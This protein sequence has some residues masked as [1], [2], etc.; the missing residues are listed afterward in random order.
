M[1]SSDRTILVVLPILALAIGFWMLVVSPK[2]SEVS[3]LDGEITTLQASIDSA[4]TEVAIA[5]QAQAAFPKNYARLVSLGT[6]V[7]EDDDQATLVHDLSEL[8]RQD[9]LSFRSFV[10]SPASDVAAPAAPAATAPTDP[11]S[12]APAEGTTTTT[13]AAPATEASAAGLPLGATVGPAGLPVTPYNLKYFG[14]FF[15]TADLFAALDA[16]V[17]VD[18]EG[19]PDVSGRLVTIDGFAMSADPI[20]GFPRVQTELAITTY[21]VPAEQGLSAG[22]T[23]AGPAPLAPPPTTVAET[24]DPTAA[25]TTAAVAP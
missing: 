21:L 20:R 22:A 24:A 18:D 17:D 14:D 10:V 19:S 25:G 5:E 9:D 7:P 16:R 12:E 4:E 6:A 2:R 8:A 23:P 3:K 11:A 13:T 15:D 1:K